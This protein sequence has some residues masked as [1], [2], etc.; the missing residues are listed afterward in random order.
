[1]RS[2]ELGVGV[3]SGGGRLSRIPARSMLL[4]RILIILPLCIKFS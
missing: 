1:M 2:W 3:G 4:G